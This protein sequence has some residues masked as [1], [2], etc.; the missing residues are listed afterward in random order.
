MARLK[1]TLQEVK[2]EH[3]ESDGSPENKAA[4]RRRQQAILSKSMRAGIRDAQVVITNPEHFAIA[5]RYRQ[6]ED[7]APTIMARG[8]DELA[9]A[10]RGFATECGV[11]IL[12]APPLARAIYFTGQ[13]GQ[14]IDTRLYL[15]VAALLAFLFRLD[16]AVA[17]GDMLPALVIPSELQFDSDGRLNP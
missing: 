3:K 5:L 16:R 15:A 1:M 4:I 17:A 13:V 11:P 12:S 6:G 10:I 8:T 7:A 9:A 2:D 14:M